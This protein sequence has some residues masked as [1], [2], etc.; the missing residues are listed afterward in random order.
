MEEMANEDSSDDQDPNAEEASGILDAEVH[1]SVAGMA[2][3][4]QYG[5]LGLD[6]G[7]WDGC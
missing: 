4:I 3:L 2:A 7:L 5:V 1:Q 6:I